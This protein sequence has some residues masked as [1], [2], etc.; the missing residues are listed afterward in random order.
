M[1]HMKLVCD[2]GILI[3]D[4][5]HVIKVHMAKYKQEQSSFYNVKLTNARYNSRRML[6]DSLVLLLIY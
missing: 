1:L 6:K 2:L 5:N 4:I 3:Q